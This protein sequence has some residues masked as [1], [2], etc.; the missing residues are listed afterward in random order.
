VNNAF[1]EVSYLTVPAPYGMSVA[2]VPTVYVLPYSPLRAPSGV[3]WEIDG[4]VLWFRWPVYV[5]ASCVQ[6]FQEVSPG[7]WEPIGDCLP[8]DEDSIVIPT[9]ETER[10]YRLSFLT[11]GGYTELTAPICI[12]FPGGDGDGGGGFDPGEDE[13]ISDLVKVTPETAQ[14]VVGFFKSVSYSLVK[15]DGNPLPEEISYSFSSFILQSDSFEDLGLT[16]DVSNKRIQGTPVSFSEPDP[17]IE[18]TVIVSGTVTIPE[19]NPRTFSKPVVLKIF[20]ADFKVFPETV[21]FEPGLFSWMSFKVGFSNGELLPGDA[22]VTISSFS[23]ENTSWAF[24]GLY[25]SPS[26]K[27]ISGVAKKDSFPGSLDEYVVMVNGV[28]EFSEGIEALTFSVPITIKIPPYRNLYIYPFVSKSLHDVPYS[29]QLYMRFSNTHEFLITDWISYQVIDYPY[30]G[31]VDSPPLVPPNVSF[32]PSTGVLSWQIEP[33]L[34]DN[35]TGGDVIISF[36]NN[37]H[38][39]GS[40]L[41]V[42]P[43]SVQ[44]TISIFNVL[45]PEEGELDLMTFQFTNDFDFESVNIESALYPLR[46]GYS[47]QLTHPEQIKWGNRAEIDFASYFVPFYFRVVYRASWEPFISDEEVPLGLKKVMMNWFDYTEAPTYPFK[48]KIVDTV[49]NTD[50][51]TGKAIILAYLNPGDSIPS[52]PASVSLNVSC[53]IKQESGGGAT[54]L[55]R[56]LSRRVNMTIT[57]LYEG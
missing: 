33:F 19:T 26:T 52:L 53:L 3:T 9:P 29:K 8:I 50:A 55:Y 54:I 11:A 49:W 5:G 57:G 15:A 40:S 12:T 30:R 1:S 41:V 38:I 35:Y 42:N 47:Y 17:Y 16:A 24:L 7:V 43:S 6:V 45:L 2:G 44:H 10:C 37:V 36:E 56:E 18:R 46:P 27:S 31:I 51:K 22:E 32:S 25:S 13:D 20:R 21:I 28:V 39:P 48:W 4:P 23:L 34:P 14:F